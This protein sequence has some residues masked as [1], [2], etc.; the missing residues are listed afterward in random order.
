MGFAL[1]NCCYRR[2]HLVH[3]F[4]KNIHKVLQARPFTMRSYKEC[5]HFWCSVL[6]EALEI[7]M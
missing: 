1:Q 3:N 2:T 6:V 5:G 7:E 4:G